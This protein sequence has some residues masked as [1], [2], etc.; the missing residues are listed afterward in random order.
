LVQLILANNLKKK[1]NIELAQKNVLI[2]EQKKEIT[3]SIEYASRI[4][5]AMLPP[6]DYIDGLLPERFIIYKPRDIVSGDF[7]YIT[8]K[9]GKV[10]CVIADCT[11]HGV[12]GAFMSMLGI[13]FLNE[14][15]SKHRD[16]PHSNEILEELRAHVI[17]SLHQTGK[18][19]ESQD[20]MDLALYIIDKEAGKMEF[21]GANNSLWIFRNGEMIEKRAD[22]MPIGIYYSLDDNSFTRHDIDLEEGDAV[23]AFSDGYYDQFGGPMQKKFLI[24]NFREMLKK[25]HKKPMEEQQR[26]MLETLE[27]WMADSAQVDDIL[28]VGVRV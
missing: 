19:G 3:D 17:K 6:G 13:S 5:N 20:G 14:I 21:S 18:S 15:I 25:I 22:K 10:I 28:V 16:L 27:A 24:K 8:E 11:G 12:P 2:T 23:Y 1:T 26:I 9:D 4:Q 7:Y